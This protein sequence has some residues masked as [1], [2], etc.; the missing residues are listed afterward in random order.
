MRKVTL[1]VCIVD[2]LLF[3]TLSQRLT[4]FS[5]Q[6]GELVILCKLFQNPFSR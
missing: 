6:Q 2:H 3:E 4:V 5:V 1:A